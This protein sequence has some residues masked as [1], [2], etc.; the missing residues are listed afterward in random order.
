MKKVA[1]SALSL[2]LAVCTAALILCLPKPAVA[3]DGT[4]VNVTLACPGGATNVGT[5]LYDE[6][7][8]QPAN[9]ALRPLAVSWVYTGTVVTN[10][11]I[12]LR[13]AAGGPAWHTI[14]HGT[15][16]G[17]SY[18]GVAFITDEWY[19]RRGDTVHVTLSG[20]NLCTVTVHCVER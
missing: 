11:T 14:S 1:L 16:G 10:K 8:A 5:D 6:G 13:K 7:I 2:A 17:A 9:S 4:P 12:I 18:S 15:G 3:A 19:W 20:T